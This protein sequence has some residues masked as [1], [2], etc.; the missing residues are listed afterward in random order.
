M[1]DKK[2]QEEI[3]KE[4]NID[5]ISNLI[6]EKLTNKNV[7]VEAQIQ[8]GVTLW[9][10]IYSPT[11]IT[12]S[13]EI[14]VSD[15]IDLLN[16]IQPN[17][18]VSIHISLMSLADNNKLIK[19]RY[20]TLKEGK[21]IEN[22][23]TI[24]TTTFLVLAIIVAGLGWIMFPKNQTPTLSTVTSSSSTLSTKTFLSR[25]E[26]GYELWA[27]KD[28]IY[29]K[30]LRESDLQRLNTNVFSFKEAVKSQ[31]GFKCVFFE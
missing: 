27:D 13:T 7:T 18:I 22:T 10:K 12:F 19:E 24:N 21:Y 9:L 14:F 29:V 16:E 30:N 3:A 20:L 5:A 15:I 26:T 25:S 8:Y 23:T 6:A 1:L 17:K 4:G 2:R 11:P 31:T 28:C